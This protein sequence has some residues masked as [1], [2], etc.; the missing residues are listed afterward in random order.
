MKILKKRLR[1]VKSV[2][3]MAEKKTVQHTSKTIESMQK[4]FELMLSGKLDELIKYCNSDP[5]FINC[6]G[7]PSHFSVFKK[8]NE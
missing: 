4:L 1:I 2:D 3:I 8:S 7:M 5:V 6:W